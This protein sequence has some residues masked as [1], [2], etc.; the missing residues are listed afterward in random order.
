MRLFHSL[1]QKWVKQSLSDDTASHDRQVTY[2]QRIYKPLRGKTKEI[3]K[4][5]IKY[6]Q[7]AI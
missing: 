4:E 1:E 5:T 3:N 7:I 2:S 6:L